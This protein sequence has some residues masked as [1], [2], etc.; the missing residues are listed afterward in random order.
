L[1]HLPKDTI[2]SS[3]GGTCPIQNENQGMAQKRFGVGEAFLAKPF[4]IKNLR[5][6][7]SANWR[8]LMADET[9][10]RNGKAD[11]VESGNIERRALVLGVSD[12]F[13]FLWVCSPS[14]T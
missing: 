14:G 7:I 9:P 12:D 3:T 10:L 8:K 13:S 6:I 5:L 1:S 4:K 11:I 2:A